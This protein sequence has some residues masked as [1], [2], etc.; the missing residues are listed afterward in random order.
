MD[1]EFLKSLELSDDAIEQI[2]KKHGQSI[3]STKQELDTLAEENSSLKEQLQ[4]RDA[5]IADLKEKAKDSEELTAK[6]DE[7]AQ[8]YE[9]EKANLTAKLEDT[10][11][12]HTLELALREAGAKNTKAVSALID[13]ESLKFEDGKLVGLDDQLAT[14][15]KE[16]DYLFNVKEEQ[17]K[18]SIVP[19]GNPNGNE[20]K[21]NDDVFAAKIAQIKGES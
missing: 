4:T 13:Q 14:I 19:S 17:P 15:Q 2:M 12:K 5:D 18:P 11:R 10:N 21:D 1:R 7:M 6:L 9:T 20:G 8:S 3:T 16:N